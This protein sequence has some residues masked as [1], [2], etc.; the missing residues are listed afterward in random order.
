MIPIAQPIAAT[1]AIT[2]GTS[3][4][5]ENPCAAIAGIARAATP[6]PSGCAVCLMP[7]A[8]PR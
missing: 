8:D 3:I 6:T 1:P 7:I 4:A 2:A 5:V